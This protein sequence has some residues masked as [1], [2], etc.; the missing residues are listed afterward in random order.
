VDK[1]HIREIIER[2]RLDWLE[3]YQKDETTMP[4]WHGIG[5]MIEQRWREEELARLMYDVERNR[6]RENNA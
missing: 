6:N 3:A 2:A 5:P 1:D 4:I